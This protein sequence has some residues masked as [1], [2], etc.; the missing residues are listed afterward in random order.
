MD[1]NS[2]EWNASEIMMAK[3]LIAS[4]NTNNNYA[5]NMYKK[6]TDNIVDVLQARFPTKGKHQVINLYVDLMVEMLQTMLSND[7]H[8]T[9]SSNLVHEE[10]KMSLD[11]LAMESMDMLGGYPVESGAK[12]KA[13]EAPCR[14]LAPPTKRQRPVKFWTKEEHRSIIIYIYMSSIP[15]THI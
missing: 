8:A 9:S 3:D 6:H 15:Y 14:Q 7:H 2:G 10:S 11:V 1:L 12:R 4:H 5:Y 13:E